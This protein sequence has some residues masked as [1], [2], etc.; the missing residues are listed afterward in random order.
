M[1]FRVAA[2]VGGIA[3][4]ALLCVLAP[5]SDLARVGYDLAIVVTTGITWYGSTRAENDRLA[6]RLIAGGIT[7]WVV[8]DLLWDGYAYLRWDRP[9][10]SVADLLYLIGYPLL[11]AGIV[12]ILMLRTPG[13]YREGLLD[14][15]AFAIAAAIA[16]WA[17]I[18]VPTT[19][20]ATL[21][22]AAIWGAY[23]FAD[24]LLF[25]AVV[26][27]VLT[28]GRRGPPTLL[29]L[30]FLTTTLLLDL[31]WTAMPLLNANFDPG[32]FNGGYPI[33]YA[34]LALAAIL[35]NG[36]E[37]TRQTSLPAGR[38]HPARFML[39]GFALMT[40]PTIAI[41]TTSD[42]SLGSE[43]FLFV[44]SMTLASIVLWRF[45]IAV[46]E[47]EHV[48]GELEHQLAH[49]HLTGLYNRQQ[50]VEILELQLARAVRT[51]TQVAV[52]YLDLDGFK[53]V[54]DTFG[55]SAGDFVLVTIAQRLRVL[56]R[57]HDVVARVG[58]DEFAISCED[59]RPRLRRRGDRGPDPLGAGRAARGRERAGHRVGEHRHHAQCGRLPR[60]RARRRGRPGHVPGQA[61]REA[62]LRPRPAGTGGRVGTARWASIRPRDGPNVSQGTRNGRQGADTAMSRDA[63]RHRERAALVVGIVGTGWIALHGSGL[64]GPLSQD[65]FVLLGATAV[66]ATVVGLRRYR[67]ARRWPFVLMAAAFFLFLVG[68]AL[69]QQFGTLG[70][71]TAHRSLIPDFLAAP[72]YVLLGLGLAGIARARRGSAG[73]DLDATLDALVAALAALVVAWAYLITPA[74]ANETAPLRV[75]LVLAAYPALSAFLVVMILQVAFVVDDRRVPAHRLLVVA[76]GCMFIG[77][78]VYMLEDARIA[79]LSLHIIDVPYALAFLAV[80]VAVL[81]PSMREL[82][83]PVPRAERTTRPSRLALVSACIGI[84]LLVTVADGHR[85]LV[86]KSVLLIVMVF[87]SSIAI[88]RVFRALRAHARSEERLVHQATH[89]ALT[90]LPNRAY[91]TDQ[92]DQALSRQAGTDI[93]LGVLFLDIDRFKVVNDSMGHNLGDELLVAVAKR[94]RGAL[95]PT[96]GD[97]P[98]RRRRVRHRA[99][100]HA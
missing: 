76:L 22:D 93:L 57:P 11:A 56:V 78:V 38:M 25:A 71:L 74:L 37:L 100:A 94:L 48:Q 45:R 10:V 47:R 43:V 66:T 72:G 87:L 40:A 81:H 98:G 21:L 19:K 70:D 39:L 18:V 91:L 8:G 24:V 12:R 6:W 82:L 59:L 63:D 23:P 27:L 42:M 51:R 61:G 95:P 31:V 5:D 65:T 58:G 60:G 54:N 50:W 52:L 89:D 49:D 2:F 83:E 67:P 16:T 55:H 17:F 9:S 85:T 32:P 44:A 99:G 26:W 80:S 73:F 7:C 33:A 35:P 79:R 3:A 88:W 86:D 69:R 97:R 34:A 46:R 14:G 36:G 64:L 96:R 30:A 84:P 13:R 20:D 15:V 28:P 1:S 62:P 90:K 77:D 92:L 4:V 53:P 75:R 29:L 41:A 68:G